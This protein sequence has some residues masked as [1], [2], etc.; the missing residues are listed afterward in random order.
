MKIVV[1]VLKKLRTDDGCVELKDTI[2][3]GTMYNVDFDSKQRGTGFNIPMQKHWKR[4]IIYVVNEIGDHVGWM[5]TELL[6]ISEP[7]EGLI[8]V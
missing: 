1:A 7:K 5:P 3:L 8:I 6:D 4:E 2:N